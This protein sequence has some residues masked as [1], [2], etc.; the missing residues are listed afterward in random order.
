MRS[1][2]KASPKYGISYFNYT[3]NQVI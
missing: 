2:A 1:V 3:R